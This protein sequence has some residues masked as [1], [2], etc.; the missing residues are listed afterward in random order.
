[1]K[2]GL[3]FDGVFCNAS[4]LLKNGA[5]YLFGVDLPENKTIEQTAVKE[6][7]LT[8]KQFKELKSFVF[9]NIS[10]NL[11]INPVED[12]DTACQTLINRGHQVKI[13]TKRNAG[14]QTVHDLCE[15][16]GI[17]IPI[18]GMKPGQPKSSVS[19]R[20]DIF[21]DDSPNILKDLEGFI[22][23]LFLFS[24]SYNQD[25]KSCSVNRVNSWSE[26]VQKVG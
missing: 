17:E 9:G 3:D 8:K 23:N 21:L 4:K 24:W 13:I 22:P 2:I 18:I 25:F 16:I 19:E 5:N 1:M 12:V 11:Q 6:K 15:K 20:F 10:R 14:V 7:I 26:F